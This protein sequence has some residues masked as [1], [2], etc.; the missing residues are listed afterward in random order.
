[1]CG[2]FQLVEQTSEG[3]RLARNNIWAGVPLVMFK[4]YSA[5]NRFGVG[6]GKYHICYKDAMISQFRKGKPVKVLCGQCVY[7]FDTD[8]CVAYVI[9]KVIRKIRDKPELIPNGFCVKCMRSVL[10]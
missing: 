3:T 2:Q 7:P 4:A 6:V 5:A 9:H 1:M 10:I 8:T